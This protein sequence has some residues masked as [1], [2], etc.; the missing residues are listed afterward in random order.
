MRR[1]FEAVFALIVLIAISPLLAVAA[2]AIVIDSR[3]GP[4]FR[5]HR[6]GLNGRAFRMWKFRTMVRNAGALG[7]GITGNNDRRI[8]RL[9]ALLRATKIDELPQFFNVVAGDMSL[10]GPRPEAPEIVALYTHEQR[11]V[12]LVKPGVTGRVQLD[13]RE[14]SDSIPPGVA[15]DEYYVQHLMPKKVDADLQYLERRTA[16]TDIRIIVETIRYVFTEL[17]RRVTFSIA[18]KRQSEAP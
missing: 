14:E 12:L 7:P 17:A 6:V 2:L 16:F 4:F 3:G 11:S 8:T 10:V 9:G 13:S 18:A 1:T 5:A 15:A